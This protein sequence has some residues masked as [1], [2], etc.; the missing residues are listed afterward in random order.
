[1]NKLKAEPE[2]SIQRNGG[3]KGQDDGSLG[4]MVEEERK[5]QAFSYGMGM[6]GE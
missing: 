3:S 4:K 1:M 5:I 2:L 6:S